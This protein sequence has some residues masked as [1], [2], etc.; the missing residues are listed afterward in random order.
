MN[1]WPIRTKKELQIKQ[2]ENIKDR[3]KCAQ[4]LKEYTKWNVP[5]YIDTIIDGN[6]DKATNFEKEFCAWPLRIFIIDQ[7]NKFKYIM[8]PDD[9]GNVDFKQIENEIVKLLDDK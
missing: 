7:E 3:I 8:Y 5:V 6:D 9:N 4:F 1:E 2:H